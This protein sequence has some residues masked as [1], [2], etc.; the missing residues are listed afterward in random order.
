MIGAS[1]S[2]G[3]SSLTCAS[4]VGAQ[5]LP[6]RGRTHPQTRRVVGGGAMV[7]QDQRATLPAHLLVV[8]QRLHQIR[9]YSLAYCVV[10][11]CSIYNKCLAFLRSLSGVYLALV[12][13][14][15]VPSRHLLPALQ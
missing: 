6:S 12:L 13:A 8:S 5:P 14:I 4:V 2:M 7:A 10:I 3:Y 11:V 9:F 15:V 1:S